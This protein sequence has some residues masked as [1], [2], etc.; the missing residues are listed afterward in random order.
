MRQEMVQD[1]VWTSTT[2]IHSP[3]PPL[4]QANCWRSTAI[5]C[6]SV[7][8]WVNLFRTAMAAPAFLEVIARQYHHRVPCRA[9]IS[10]E[11]VLFENSL[12]KQLPMAPD[13]IAQ[14]VE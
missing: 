1:L 11:I 3:H 14:S 5:L 2:M 13:C 10:R 12:V 4:L 9:K 6:S 8:K 7:Y